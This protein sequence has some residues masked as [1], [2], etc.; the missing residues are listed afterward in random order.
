ML[1]HA[2]PERGLRYRLVLRD[3][4]YKCS[5]I[6]LARAIALEHRWLV[7]NVFETN[8]LRASIMEADMACQ[9]QLL[10]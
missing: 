3:D 10:Q 4:I 5:K 2:L 7:S 1:V 8:K 9:L 6:Y